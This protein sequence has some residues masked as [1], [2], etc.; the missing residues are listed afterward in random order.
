MV[1]YEITTPFFTTA[2][3]NHWRMEESAYVSMKIGIQSFK[4]TG[5]TFK[6]TKIAATKFALASLPWNEVSSS[7]RDQSEAVL[8]GRMKISKG[9]GTKVDVKHGKCHFFILNKIY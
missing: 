3:K 1:A 2:P 6:S 7:K 5:P 9:Q 8:V 4:G